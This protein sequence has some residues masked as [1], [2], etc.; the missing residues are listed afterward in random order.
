[1][2]SRALR[3][4]RRG[5]EASVR[6]VFESVRKAIGRCLGENLAPDTRRI[7]LELSLDSSGGIKLLKVLDPSESNVNL[8]KCLGKVLAGLAFEKPAG[9]GVAKVIVE[10]EL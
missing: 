3:R 1:M 4:A 7:K 2:R 9:G 8:Q 5:P 6:N 10:I